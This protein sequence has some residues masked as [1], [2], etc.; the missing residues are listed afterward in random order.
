[1]NERIQKEL[2]GVSSALHSGILTMKQYC[3]LYAVQQALAWALSPNA[4]RSPGI[5]V[6]EGGCQPPIRESRPCS[7]PI[8]QGECPGS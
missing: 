2:D 7:A 6:M 1:M 8:H 4:A 3:E 5:V